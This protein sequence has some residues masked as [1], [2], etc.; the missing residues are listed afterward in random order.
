MKRKRRKKRS[1]ISQGGYS[2]NL[3]NDRHCRCHD[4][5][6]CS[7]NPG[8]QGTKLQKNAKID[9][10]SEFL[11]YLTGAY[12]C[13]ECIE[14]RSLQCDFCDR[15]GRNCMTFQPNSGKFTG[16]PTHLIIVFEKPILKVSFEKNSK[17]CSRPKSTLKS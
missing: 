3:R 1:Q 8:Y 11:L 5:I 4:K 14:R 7:T 10:N 9:A 15:R 2:C 12:I 16:I 17:K 13:D 6:C